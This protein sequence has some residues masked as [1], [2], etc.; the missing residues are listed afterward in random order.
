LLY[1]SAKLNILVNASKANV[2]IVQQI[3]EKI[4]IVNQNIISVSNLYFLNEDVRTLLKNDWTDQYY[5]EML[6]RRSI[7]KT[8]ETMNSNFV[9]MQHSTVLFGFNGIYY[10]SNNSADR[11]NDEVRNGGY[12]I[13]KGDWKFNYYVGEKPQLFNIRNDPGEFTD[14]SMDPECAPII[15]DMMKELFRKVNPEK[16]NE[17]VKADQEFRR[18]KV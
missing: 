15:E 1:N 14:L 13:V 18:Q 12:M 4:E 5:E 16:V 6:T 7:Q 2:N 8:M 3:S 11:R 9:H 10:T 17:I